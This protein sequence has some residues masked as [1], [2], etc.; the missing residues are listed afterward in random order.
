MVDELGRFRGA[1][2]IP[3]F[4]VE[5]FPMFGKIVGKLAAPTPNHC[6]SVAPY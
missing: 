3:R 2:R 4:E 6:A 5:K 1:C